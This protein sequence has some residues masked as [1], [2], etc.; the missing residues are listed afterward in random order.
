MAHWF[1]SGS[2]EVVVQTRRRWDDRGD[3]TVLIMEHVTSKPSELRLG[4]P[5][6]ALYGLALD[7]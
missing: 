5:H 3:D 7:G 4:C 2:G 1:L 6:A